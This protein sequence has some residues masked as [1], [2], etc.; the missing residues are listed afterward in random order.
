MRAFTEYLPCA[1]TVG[2]GCECKDHLD[3]VS[4]LFESNRGGRYEQRLYNKGRAL[5]QCRTREL[6]DQQR[7]QVMVARKIWNCSELPFPKVSPRKGNSAFLKGEVE[8]RGT[9]GYV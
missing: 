3:P 6:L 1:R 9:L 7:T 8:L 4:A 2:T 5:F